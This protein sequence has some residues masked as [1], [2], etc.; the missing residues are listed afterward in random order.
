MRALATA[1]IACCLALGAAASSQEVAGVA[2]PRLRVPVYIMEYHLWYDAPIGAEGRPGWFHGGASELADSESMGPDW[3]RMR[4]GV[5]WPLPGAYAS[6]DPGIIRWQLQCIKA[7]GVDGVFVQLFPHWSRPE[8]FHRLDEF[9]ALLRIAE[10]VGV[11]VG[12]HDEIQFRP[13][14]AK[15]AAIFARRAGETLQRFAASPAFLRIGGRP[16]YAFQWW[17]Q[18]QAKDFPAMPH[19]DLQRVFTDA[20]RIAGQACHWMPF[21]HASDDALLALPGVG[22]SVTMSNSNSQFRSVAADPAKRMQRFAGAAGWNDDPLPP[23]MIDSEVAQFRA[24]RAA[25]PGKPLGLWAYPGFNNTT[26]RAAD[27]HAE[28]LPRRGGRTLAEALGAFQDYGC[29]FVMIS[30]WNDWEENTAIEPGLL[31]DGYAG[32]PY[33][34]CR[35]VA[36]AKGLEFVP[37]PLPPKE[38]VD[39]L[40]WQRLYGIDRTPPR[41]TRVRSLP[42]EAAIVAEV[43]DSGSAVA[44]AGLRDRGDL[45]IGDGLVPAIAADADGAFAIAPGASLSL[46]IDRTRLAAGDWWLAVECD[47]AAAGRLSVR[48]PSAREVGDDRPGDEG[49]IR[50]RASITLAGSGAWRADVRPLRLVDPAKDAPLTVA[51]EGKGGP[52]RIARV[53]LFRASGGDGAPGLEISGAAPAS[54]VKTFRLDAPG[55]QRRPLPHAVYLL[56]RDAAGNVS[57]PVPVAAGRFSGGVGNRP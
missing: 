49:H 27:D 18:L 50:L 13:A 48:Y 54:Q 36:A 10:E 21:R 24:A 20:E 42:L 43:V 32:D 56:L 5:G 15:E 38:S 40:L 28:W 16:A 53:H 45:A 2:V 3:M 4:H 31:Y 34:Y 26:Q 23:V 8:T 47:D 55:L 11:K 7:T 9:A 29:D 33:L 14:R 57:H 35:I 22:S 1:A 44:G 52:L 30:S 17:G 39:P 51:W 37:P 6:G 46:A 41:L 12:I 25:H 19:A